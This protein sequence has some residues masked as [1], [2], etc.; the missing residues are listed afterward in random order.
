MEAAP[1]LAM[2][3]GYDVDAGLEGMGVPQSAIYAAP[4]S[5]DRREPSPAAT[6]KEGSDMTDPVND[7]AADVAAAPE[8]QVEVTA[9]AAQPEAEIGMITDGAY[10][11]LAGQFASAEL[12]DAAYAELE[13]IEAG[14]SLRIDGV[15]IA[16]ADQ[17]G[18]IQFGRVTDHSTKTGLK[19][20][21]VGGAVLGIIFPPSILASAVGL[22]VVGSVLG[23]FRN[24]SRRSTLADELEGLV[25]PGTTALIVL[26]EDEA[27]VEVEK[28]LAKADRIVTK[29]VDK[30]LAA[31]IDREAAAAKDA[32]ATA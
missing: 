2:A 4:V 19:W 23:K 11:L 3:L 18:K 29:A 20:G 21:V 28:A 30:Q 5:L 22:G 7:A 17:D 25:S 8:Q 32:I 31:E 10:Y 9:G 6:R 12:A 27:V 1:K 14:T 13:A 26:A 16:S 15:V 24:L